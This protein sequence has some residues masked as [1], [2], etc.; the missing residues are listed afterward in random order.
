V[1]PF[2]TSAWTPAATARST[3]GLSRAGA[4]RSA[5]SNGVTRIPEIP[6][7]AFLSLVSIVVMVP[8]LR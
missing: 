7:S 3:I 2:A 8:L 4:R 5:A 6:A 1:L